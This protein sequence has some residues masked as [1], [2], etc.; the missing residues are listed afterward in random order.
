LDKNHGEIAKLLGKTGNDAAGITDFQTGIKTLVEKQQKE[1]ELTDTDLQEFTK[2][3]SSKELQD[4][5]N[6]LKQQSDS[7][8]SQPNIDNDG[9]FLGKSNPNGDIDRACIVYR[10]NGGK[11]K[12]KKTKS[13]KSKSK[14]TKTKS[15]KKRTHKKKSKK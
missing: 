2:N 8:T 3:F 5:I 4:K 12:S 1:L 7:A 11:T 13:N 9:V 6:G 14:K 10:A 15:A